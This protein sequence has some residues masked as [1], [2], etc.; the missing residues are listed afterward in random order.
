LSRAIVIGAGFGGIAA[1][2]R[3]RKRGYDVVI[4]DR[5]DKIGGRGYVFE[6]NGF[7]Y[8][9]GPTVITAPFLIEELF[10]LFQRNMSD[11]LQL[12]PIK[13][14]YLIRFDDGSTFKYGGTLEETL[15]E[16]RRF[17]PGDVDGY[18]KLLSKC[19]KIFEVGF[20]K[21]GDKP[22]LSAGSMLAVAPDMMALESYLTVYQLVSRYI[23]NEK[24]R[25][26]C[27][28]HPLLVGGNPFSTTS[29][30][31]LIHYLERQYGVWYAMGGT[32]AIVKSLARLMAEV[33]IK[34][35][36]EC[37]VTKIITKAGKAVGVECA[38]G[39]T[40][41]A[42]IVVANADPP[43]VYKHMLESSDR[44]KWTDRRI[45][46]MKYS[47]G[48]FVVYFGT[49]KLYPELAH[50]SII[51]GKRYEG[52]LHDIFDRKI[53]AE[54]FSLY[55]HAPTRTDPTMAPPGHECFY[56]LAPVPNL[57]GQINWQ[58]EG[59]QFAAKILRY[60]E[61]T[62]LPSLSEH[63]VDQSF[64]TPEHF[65]DN[66]LSL[67][68]T[69]FSV[70]PTLMQSAYFRFH[71]KSEDIENLYFVGA[72]THPGAGLPGVLT[73]A[74]VLDRIIPELPKG[75]DVVESRSE[76]VFTSG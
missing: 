66:L 56:V 36:L 45:E 65:R 1:A 59:E 53:L 39:K 40:L 76:A 11:Y 68:G 37:T 63:I 61:S 26:V 8:D 30:Y 34:T 2:L 25:K 70:Q 75:N 55:L 19:R 7:T 67:Y 6:R 73:S 52:L 60:L 15:S 16:V 12:V 3:L 28:F 29:I 54:D 47:M 51:L 74:K 62:L 69:G 22:F 49:N 27:T 17:S 44:K 4:L 46:R 21:L 57:Q 9:A 31:T 20:L 72:G 33:G 24:L 38:D 71:N 50:H 64:I 10:K 32:G 43:F 23:K 58:E 42:E 41:K 14:W 5:Q 35:Q 18:K 48:L 13:P